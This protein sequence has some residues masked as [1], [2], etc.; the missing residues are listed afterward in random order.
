MVVI[1]VFVTLWSY[2]LSLLHFPQLSFRVSNLDKVIEVPRPEMV[3]LRAAVAGMARGVCGGRLWRWGVAGND[4]SSFNFE[5]YR[6]LADYPSLFMCILIECITLCF[7]DGSF[8]SWP[9]AE[10]T[11]PHVST[12]HEG[13][14][15]L[16]ASHLGHLGLQQPVVAILPLLA[17]TWTHVGLSW[18]CPTDS[19]N[20][21]QFTHW[22]LVRKSFA[23]GSYNAVHAAFWL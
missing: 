8:W 4:G 11:H 13:R 9:V 21:P 7:G 20:M 19:L 5:V 3:A 1:C 16:A 14:G 12:R 18:S 23:R 2:I 10:F 15:Q 22:T 17:P 6:I